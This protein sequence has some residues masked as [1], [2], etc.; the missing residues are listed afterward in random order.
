LGAGKF[1]AK[2]TPQFTGKAARRCCH[3]G[4]VNFVV[5]YPG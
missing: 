2:F 1:T 5:N 4:I 3:T